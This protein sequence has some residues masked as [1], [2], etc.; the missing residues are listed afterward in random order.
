MGGGEDFLCAGAIT[1]ERIPIR[2]S[3]LVFIE[4]KSSIGTGPG[5]ERR[6]FYWYSVS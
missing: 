3:L 1:N 6:C 2:E 4:K 5:R